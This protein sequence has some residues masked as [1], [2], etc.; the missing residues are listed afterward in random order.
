M[1]ACIDFNFPQVGPVTADNMN[2]CP[3][4]IGIIG[5]VAIVTWVVDGRKHFTGPDTGGVVNAVEAE[6]KGLGLG[7]AASQATEE[8]RTGS[9]SGGSGE[10]STV[11]EKI[12]EKTG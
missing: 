8:K 11:P 9:S 12:I 7:M 2:Y 4:A 10:G 5:L 6:E 3:A 1:F